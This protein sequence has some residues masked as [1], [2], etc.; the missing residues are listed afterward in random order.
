MISWL[1]SLRSILLAAKERL[2]W[3]INKSMPEGWLQC[4][5]RAIESSDAYPSSVLSSALAVPYLGFR[6]G[7]GAP[8]SIPPFHIC[9]RP[10]ADPHLFTFP[11]GSPPSRPRRYSFFRRIFGSKKA[12]E[13][14]K[15][16]RLKSGL[17]FVLDQRPI[18]KHDTFVY[19]LSKIHHVK[20]EVVC[21]RFELFRGSLCFYLWQPL[22]PPPFPV[23][24]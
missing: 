20:E 14:E 22:Q 8:L 4:G 7:W 18:D 9:L 13:S 17:F 12:N 23:K 16:R 1:S 15:V 3:S 11:C 19:G 24:P 10:T 2:I 5:C 21:V 6:C